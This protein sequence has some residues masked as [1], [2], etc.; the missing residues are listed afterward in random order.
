MEMGMGICVSDVSV[1]IRNV[2]IA[3]LYLRDDVQVHMLTGCLAPVKVVLERST[4]S[5]LSMLSVAAPSV[6]KAVESVLI[7]L[8]SNVGMRMVVPLKV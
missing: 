1:R 4:L 5:T 8:M 6:G 7:V 2:S 3:L